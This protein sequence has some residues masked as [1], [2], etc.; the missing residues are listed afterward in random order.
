MVAHVTPHNTTCETADDEAAAALAGSGS[1]GGGGD[2][3][4]TGL[5]MA[6][7]WR[8]STWRNEGPKL[9]LVGDIRVDGRGL[10]LAERVQ[11]ALRSAARRRGPHGALELGHGTSPA[12]TS[13]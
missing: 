13:T 8:R 11:S 6:F 4:P 12:V 1:G 3:A 10:L 5:F 7:R 2:W 9:G